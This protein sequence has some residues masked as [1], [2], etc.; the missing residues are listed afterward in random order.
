MNAAVK[1]SALSRAMGLADIDLDS[2]KPAPKAS[3]VRVRERAPPT[4]APDVGAKFGDWTVTGPFERGEHGNVVPVVCKCGVTNAMSAY[5]LVAGRSKSCISCSSK[6]KSE[7]CIDALHLRLEKSQEILNA[8]RKLDNTV[9]ALGLKITYKVC[10][11]N[12]E[13][14]I[15]GLRISGI[16]PLEIANRIGSSLTTIRAWQKG[17]TPSRSKAV[18]NIVSLGVETLGVAVMSHYGVSVA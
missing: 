13:S 17:R 14:I 6:K 9:E 8:R 10:D 1:S 4:P 5:K 15:M 11:V 16:R 12:F 2:I 7:G 3:A 18:D